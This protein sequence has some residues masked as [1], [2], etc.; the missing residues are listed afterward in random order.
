MSY[1]NTPMSAADVAA[2]LGNRN[3][4]GMGNMGEWIFGLIVLAAFL[5]GD[6]FGGF[7]GN[8]NNCGGGQPVTEAALCNSMNFNDLQNAVGRLSDNQAAIARQQ[9]NATCNLGY[10]MLEQNANTRELVAS[11]AYEAARQTDQCCCDTKQLI[12]ET[13]YKNEQNKC[14]ILSAIKEGDWNAERR[15][16]EQKIDQL[17][18]QNTQVANAYQA[19]ETRNFIA[20]QMC[21]VPKM[22]LTFTYAVPWSW[23]QGCCTDNCR[24]R[25]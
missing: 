21:G 9:D 13:Q 7:G 11:K 25:F 14:E 8:K 6:G 24:T 18:A 1:D 4:D 20:E 22:P 16:L 15:C 23:N 19:Q 10:T 12:L 3:G 5:R 2:V 17:T